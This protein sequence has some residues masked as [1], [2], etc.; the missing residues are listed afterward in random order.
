M[1][2]LVELDTCASTSTWAL[3]HLGRLA[4]GDVVFTRRQTAGRGREGRVWLAPPGV[5]TCSV[6]LD[7]GAAD[8]RAVALAAGLACIHAI[9]DL[10][11]G[12]DGE[13]GIKWPNDVLLRH[14]KLAGILCEV[15]DGRLVVGIGLNR[16]AELPEALAATSLHL[17]GP[18]PDET[19]LLVGIRSYLLEAVGL[20]AARGTAA[21]LPQLRARDVLL[22]RSLAVET[23]N[24]RLDG[25]G[26]GIDDEGRLLL[27]VAHGGIAA[28]EAGHITA[29]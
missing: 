14:R 19:G 2:W 22:G 8:Q 17:H 6:V 25:L 12:L 5:L 27:V 20:L 7:L 10:M 29:W 28:V 1:N 18:P 24:G 4:H 23:R 26:G 21:L 11:P 3:E 13:L 16:T 15:S 9:V